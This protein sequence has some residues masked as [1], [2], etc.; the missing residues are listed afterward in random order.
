MRNW[1][2]IED[3]QFDYFSLLLILLGGNINYAANTR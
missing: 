3:I 1:E 2:L